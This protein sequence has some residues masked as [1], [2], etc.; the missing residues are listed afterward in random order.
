MRRLIGAVLVLSLAGPAFGEEG[1]FYAIEPVQGFDR[2]WR[3]DL[4]GTTAPI[5]ENTGFPSIDLLMWDHDQKR[6]YAHDSEFGA[7]IEIDPETGKGESIGKPS[8][9]LPAPLDATYANG[10]IYI[11]DGIDFPTTRTIMSLDI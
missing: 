2:L 9:E 8:K 11:L 1:F 4:D 6:L 10:L 5:G 3:I 7:I